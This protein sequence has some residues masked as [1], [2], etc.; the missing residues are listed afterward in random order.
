MN[1]IVII[2]LV[3]GWITVCNAVFKLYHKAHQRRKAKRITVVD[4][5]AEIDLSAYTPPTT[6]TLQAD[7]PQGEIGQGLETQSE[8]KA[9]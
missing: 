8:D 5:V 2:G 7:N 4:K 9:V 1:F 6:E 3:G